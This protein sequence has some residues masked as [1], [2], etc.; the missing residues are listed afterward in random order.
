MSTSYTFAGYAY[1]GRHRASTAGL[2]GNSRPAASLGAGALLAAGIAVAG[3]GSAGAVTAADQ[4]SPA[5]R[6]AADSSSSGSSEGEGGAGGSSEEG[7]GAGDAS[8]SSLSGP[9]NDATLGSSDFTDFLSGFTEQIPG[10][11]PG[12]YIG[13]TDGPSGSSGLWDF[14]LKPF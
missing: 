13:S 5:G 4:Q 2:F 12:P 7:N 9:L 11:Q 10:T 14:N 6:E 1:R 8:G 3:A